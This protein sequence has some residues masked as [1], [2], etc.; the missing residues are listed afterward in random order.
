MFPLAGRA[1][2][3]REATPPTDEEVDEAIAEFGGDTREAVRALLH[4]LEVLAR[5]YERRVSRGFV[6]G[7]LPWKRGA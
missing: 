1:L 5:D 2:D 3:G 6:R 4:D 7:T